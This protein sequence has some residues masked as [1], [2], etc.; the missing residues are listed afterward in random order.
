MPSADHSHNRHTTTL[1]KMT[2][3]RQHRQVRYAG[4]YNTATP[5]ADLHRAKGA[6]DSPPNIGIV[7]KFR[8]IGNVCMPNLQTRILKFWAV[9]SARNINFGLAPGNH[10]ILL[11]FFLKYSVHFATSPVG[12]PKTPGWIRPCT[13]LTLLVDSDAGEAAPYEDGKYGR[14]LGVVCDNVDCKQVVSTTYTIYTKCLDSRHHTYENRS[15]WKKA[16]EGKE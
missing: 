13:P 2:A 16:T 12:F 4:Q 1:D 5:R 7:L 6:S 15:G 10:V 3:F 9:K 8:K 11:F 14:L